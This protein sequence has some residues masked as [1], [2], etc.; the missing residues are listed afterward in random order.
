M[1]IILSRKGVALSV[2]AVSPGNGIRSGI[3]SIK[4]IL[5]RIITRLTRSD[6]TDIQ[7]GTRN[8]VRK[9][10]LTGSGDIDHTI[11][12]TDGGVYVPR[13][14][15]SANS[16]GYL[17]RFEGDPF[18][19]HI[20]TLAQEVYSW[21]STWDPRHYPDTYLQCTTYASMVYLLNGIDLR[22]TRLGDARNWPNAKDRFRSETIA[23]AQDPPQPLDALV[24]ASGTDNHVAVITEVTVRVKRE[25][26][27]YTVSYI[28]GNSTTT[29]GSIE[30]IRESSS[31]L[32]IGDHSGGAAWVPSHLLRPIHPII[33][34]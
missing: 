17:S 7:A 6:S 11:L 21:D 10:S 18:G 3:K 28:Q 2:K 24:W 33:P 8:Q 1:P 4:S 22:G 20:P 16:Q 23:S 31:G 5:S 30:F 34:P 13:A 15:L 27:V 14:R 9:S 32:T 12:V 26:V 29:Y 25:Q 19:T